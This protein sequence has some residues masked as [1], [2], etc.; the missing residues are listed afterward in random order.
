MPLDTSFVGRA[1]PAETYAVGR[2]KVREFAL[3]VGADDPVHHD[4]EAARTAGYPDVVAPPTFGVV[5]TWQ[6]TRTVVDDPGL[7]LDFARVVHREQGIESHRPVHAGDEV[8]TVVSI[9][10][11]REL[12]GNDVVTFRADVTDTDGEPVLTTTS[13]LVGR[14]EPAS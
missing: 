6:A 1:W 13:T 8:T 4:P 10:D 12:A 14:A 7:G 2:E 9:S 3:A 5:F 11:V